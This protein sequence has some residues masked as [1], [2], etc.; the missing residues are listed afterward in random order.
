[1]Q[2]GV[3]DD[4][5]RRGDDRRR[6]QRGPRVCFHASPGERVHADRRVR[7]LPGALRAD[8]LRAGLRG[9]RGRADA[10]RLAGAGDL[11]ESVEVLSAGAGIEAHG[12]EAGRR[13]DRCGRVRAGS[14]ASALAIHVGAAGARGEGGAG[15]SG[16]EEEELRCRSRSTR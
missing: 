11:R 12:R 4:R 9:E 15:G 2:R 14:A 10:E 5:R 8:L 1:M 7:R 3:E 13:G 16:E 6:G